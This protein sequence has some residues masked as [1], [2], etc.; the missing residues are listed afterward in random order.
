MADFTHL[1]LHSSFSLLDGMNKIPELCKRVKDLGMSSVALTDHGNMM[2]TVQFYQ[3]AKKHGVKPIFG[4]EGYIVKD[5]FDKKD[6]S[7]YHLLLLAKNKVGYKNLIKICSE[8]YVS[9]FMMKPR[10]DLQLLKEHSE[11]LIVSTSC[12]KGIVTNQ[13]LKDKVD[14]GIEILRFLMKE[15]KDDLYIELMN[16]GIPE[17]LK[18]LPMLQNVAQ[19]HK[20]KVI[21]TND[22]HYLDKSDHAAHDV[23]LCIQTKT[24][25]KDDNRLLKY[26]TP[27]FYIKSAE[28]MA[29][30]FPKE[31]LDNTMEIS[32]KCNVELELGKTY[33]PVFP[34]PEDDAFTQWLSDKKEDST[35]GR[36]DNYLKYLCIQ[37]LRGMFA[38]GKLPSAKKTVYIDRLK[39]EL[40]VLKDKSLADYF[41]V[42]SDYTKW[43]ISK[44]IRVGPGRGSAAG[45][46]VSYLLGITQVD[47]IKYDLLFER[48]INP[49]RADFPDIDLDFQDTRRQEVIDYIVE[50]YGKDKTCLIGTQSKMN[51]KVCI[52]DV[53]RALGFSIADQ[54][55]IAERVPNLALQSKPMLQEYRE[56]LP[57]VAEVAAEFPEV[58]RIAERLE[59][60]HRHTGIHAAG[61]IIASQ[62]IADLVPLHSVKQNGKEER[63]IVSQYDKK[64]LEA[65]GLVKMDVLGLSTLSILDDA[66]KLIEKRHGIVLELPA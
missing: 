65:C 59:T 28:E 61:I 55:R 13:F 1:H 54:N 30:I 20:L 12:L 64:D 57:Q 33:F 23:L 62:A 19:D 58:F 45:S 11:G 5:R 6:R 16:H 56:T 25:T 34:I 24:T 66:I 21:A 15:F 53:A 4:L 37:S 48:F 2:G 44:G 10:F 38:D 29:A 43:A 41:L 39:H 46:L 63:I 42:V 50:K 40:K 32:E 8:A 18:V 47:P 35:L 36:S 51:A 17:Q 49:H 9:G 3:E 31:Y 22:A 26:K 7:N 60:L 14:D 52:R 27:E